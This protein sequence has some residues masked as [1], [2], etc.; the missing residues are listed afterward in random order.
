MK[1]E[2]RKKLSKGRI[3]AIASAAVIGAVF[4]AL[5]IANAFIPVKYLTAYLVARLENER[6]VLRVTFVDVGYGDCTICELPDGK[7]LMIDGGDGAYP[8]NLAILGALNGRGIDKIDYL[9]CSSVL[10]EY[11]GGL[12]E[13]IKYKSVGEIFMPAV[14]NIYISSSYAQFV[15]AA[16]QSGARL[17]VSCYGAGAQGEDYYFAF[18]SPSPPENPLGYYEALNKSA[19]QE[20]IFNASAVLWLEYGQT[21]FIFTSS[22]GKAALEGIIADY[23]VIT[24]TGGRYEPLPGHE[25]NLEGCDV[26]SVP[27]HGRS[28]CTSAEWYDFIKPSLAVI[29]VGENYSGYPSSQ[30]LADIGS[31][32]SSPLLTSVHGDIQIKATPQGFALQ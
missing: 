25:A 15:S 10:G 23:S 21:S 31:V 5:V 17:T 12:S 30:A 32:I 14:D 29:S 3:A 24:S 26:V 1:T 16:R 11:C 13:I 4:L 7:V 2:K 9:V 19:T 8:H 22:A 18:L 27:G 20:N 6:G 28:E